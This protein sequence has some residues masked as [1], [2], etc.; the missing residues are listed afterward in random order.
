MSTKTRMRMNYLIISIQ[1]III[2][3][4]LIRKSNMIKTLHFPYVIL[5]LFPSANIDELRLH[6]ITNFDVLGTRTSPTVFYQVLGAESE[7]DQENAWLV[8]IFENS[9]TSIFED[10][11]QFLHLKGLF[12]A[13]ALSITAK[14]II[15]LAS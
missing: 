3:K 2:Y 14:K 15:R 13:R 5:I 9:R 6:C 10:F 7:N 8:L 11:P 4:T 1:N 12:F